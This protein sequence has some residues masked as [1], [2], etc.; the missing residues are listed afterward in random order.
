M[1]IDY[2]RD[3]VKRMVNDG[4]L[5]V[6]ALRDYDLVL[7]LTNG[8][9]LQEAAYDHNIT[10]RQVIRIKQKYMRSR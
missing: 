3:D 9:S 8:K 6:Q 1:I 5:P 4:L 10:K 7:D 2:T